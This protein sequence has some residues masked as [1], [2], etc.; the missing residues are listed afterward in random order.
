MSIGESGRHGA[1]AAVTARVSPATA[2]AYSL[3]VLKEK[4]VKKAVLSEEWI[5]FSR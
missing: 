1:A 2:P 3:H 4:R 5:V